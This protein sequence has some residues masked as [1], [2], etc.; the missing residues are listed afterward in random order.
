MRSSHANPTLVNPAAGSAPVRFSLQGS[1]LLS[2]HSTAP[3]HPMLT[4]ASLVTK[5]TSRA[6]PKGYTHHAFRERPCTGQQS[7]KLVKSSLSLPEA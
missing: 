1:H 2:E 7:H 6:T 4:S 3:K 5:T